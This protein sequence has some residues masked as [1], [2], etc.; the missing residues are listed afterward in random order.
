MEI[1]FARCH[2]ERS[3]GIATG[4]IFGGPSTLLGV[5]ESEESGFAGVAHEE[6]AEPSVS[7]SSRCPSR[8]SFSKELATNDCA[9]AAVPDTTDALSRLALDHRR[10]ISASLAEPRRADRIVAFPDDSD[11]SKDGALAWVDKQ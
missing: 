9:V 2:P 5:T 6:F 8:R 3:R 11:W 1:V 10:W 4:H 7:I